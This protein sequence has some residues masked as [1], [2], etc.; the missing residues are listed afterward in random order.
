MQGK[1]GDAMDR[2]ASNYRRFLDGDESAFDDIVN[3]YR[4]GLIMFINRYV[5]D[6]EA[7]EDIAI[8]VFMQLV[9]HRRRYNFKVGLKTYLFMMAR[10]RAIDYIRHEKKFTMV[11]YS[12][13]YEQLT[14]F[15]GLE[16]TVLDRERREVVGKAVE[17]LP[18]KMR[19]AV[20]LVYF[21]GMSYKDA[22]KV[23]KKTAKQVDNLLYRAK[24]ELRSILG[25][26]G[27]L[28]L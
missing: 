16:D 18:E 27:E 17:K 28:L 8:D 6:I 25:K 9:I 12:E 10:S 2:G 21:E 19:L 13:E 26:E 14:D 11:E 1:G 24:L 20:Y 5:H 15:F 23:M 22:A 4:M 3:E 7:S